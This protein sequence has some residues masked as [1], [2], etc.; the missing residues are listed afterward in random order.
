MFSAHLPAHFRLPSIRADC[1]LPPPTAFSHL[2][3]ALSFLGS[4]GLSQTSLT[5][6]YHHCEDSLWLQG[7][8]CSECPGSQRSGHQVNGWGVR[9]LHRQAW[10]K[11]MLWW[12]YCFETICKIFL[13]LEMKLGDGCLLRMHEEGWSPL[14]PPGTKEKRS[15]GLEP[16]FYWFPGMQRLFD[17]QASPKG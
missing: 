12:A 5:K 16:H 13:R 3:A 17:G 11:P 4:S 15:R 2:L 7:D 10:N 9:M 14:P 8:R 1:P 6:P